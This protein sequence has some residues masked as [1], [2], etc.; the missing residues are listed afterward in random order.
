MNEIL[1]SGQV[2]HLDN[3][4]PPQ[5]PE[6]P[7]PEE[8]IEV[9]PI[10]TLVEDSSPEHARQ[11]SSVPLGDSI[12]APEATDEINDSN[13]ESSNHQ[14][15]AASEE[16]SRSN[17]IEDQ[18]PGAREPA[19]SDDVQVTAG[20]KADMDEGK[21]PTDPSVS[22]PNN[23]ALQWQAYAREAPSFTVSTVSELCVIF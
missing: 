7:R 6:P 11:D 14:E 22:D 21:E 20:D 18:V 9:K 13:V 16:L 1:P 10:N 23:G 12:L 2:V 3:L 17:P 19:S 15:E 5:K 8:S 4:K